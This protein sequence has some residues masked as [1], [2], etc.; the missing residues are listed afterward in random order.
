[1]INGNGDS[2]VQALE[3]GKCQLCGFTFDIT[4]CNK[5]CNSCPLPISCNLIKCPNCGYSYPSTQT[6]IGNLLKRITQIFKNK[7]R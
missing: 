3:L 7:N 4:K 6:S 5:S 1:M 2:S